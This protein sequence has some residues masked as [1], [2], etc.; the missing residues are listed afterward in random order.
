VSVN[1][2]DWPVAGEEGLKLKEAPTAAATVTV[3]LV[4]FE[5]EPLATVKV[6]VFGPAVT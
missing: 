5:V 3:R 4:V 6:T 1:C 2:T